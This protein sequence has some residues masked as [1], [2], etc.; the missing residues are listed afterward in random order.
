MSKQATFDVIIIGGGHA[1]LSAALTL[2][3]QLHTVLIL[4]NKKPRNAWS[5]PTH[6]VSGCEGRK[7]ETLR[8][9]AR[10]EL[11]HT[12]LVT[13]VD[14]EAES[15]VRVDNTLIVRDEQGSR[16]SGRKLLIAVGK[17]N[18]MPA[19]PGYSE[20]YPERM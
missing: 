3:R 7:P 19:I 8:A 20:N 1:G 4:D 5:L 14:L 13:F 18:M 12:E 6:I 11:A 16:W 10:E 17:R 2:Y 15:V 9:E